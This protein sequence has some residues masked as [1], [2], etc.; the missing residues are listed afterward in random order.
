MSEWQPI[1]TAPKDGTEIMLWRG[2]WPCPIFAYWDDLTDP[3]RGFWS[4]CESILGDAMDGMVEDPS[5]WM[6]FP[7]PPSVF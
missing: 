5:H 2:D 7:T 1:E 6:S 3:D 4:A